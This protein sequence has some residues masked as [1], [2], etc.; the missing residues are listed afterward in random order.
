MSNLFKKKSHSEETGAGIIIAVLVLVIMVAL[1]TFMSYTSVRSLEKGS[2]IQNLNASQN[3][4]DTAISN[5]FATVNSAQ[6]T[7]NKALE[8]HLGKANAQ[9]GTFQA[10]EIDPNIGDGSYTWKWWA[11]KPA[12]FS[13]GTTYYITAIGYLN[14]ETEPEARK[15]KVEISSTTTE[16]VSYNA[17]N[18]VSYI[19]TLGGSFA[20]GALGTSRVETGK[21]VKMNTY[22]SNNMQ[23]IVGLDVQ[24]KIATNGSMLLGDGTKGDLIFMGHTVDTSNETVCS[25]LACETNPRTNYEYSTALSYS[26]MQALAKCPAGD[27]N[28]DWI[29]SQHDGLIGYDA[30]PKCYNN[31]IFDVDTKLSAV[32][33]TGNPATMYAR[34]NVTIKPGVEVSRQNSNVRGPYAL[35]IIGSGATKFNIE[36]GAQTNPTKFTGVVVGANMECNIGTGAGTD[37]A[38]ATS[39][40]TMLYGSVACHTVKIGNNATIWWDNQLDKVT[41]EGSPTAKKVWSAVSYEEL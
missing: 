25:G 27:S 36:N 14:E 8:A 15:V 6:N 11:E 28:P 38:T 37:G 17:D 10:N 26:R 39:Y 20:F 3:A 9:Y 2:S 23:P 22:N 41:K 32:F 1:L 40:G 4:V 18:T 33:S 19:S 16:G 35:Q 7:Q 13:S 5:M 24:G 30:N 12:G 29:A 31:I 21:N 34:G